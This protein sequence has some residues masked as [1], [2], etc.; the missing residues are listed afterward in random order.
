MA[1]ANNTV[2]SSNVAECSICLSPLSQPGMDVF[3]TSCQHQFHFQCL[4]KNVQAQNA[5]CPLCRAHLA[6]LAQLINGSPIASAAVPSEKAPLELTPSIPTQ[7]TSRSSGLWSTLQ[8]SIS[9]VFS[10]RKTHQV[11]L[12]LPRLRVSGF[13]PDW[14]VQSICTTAHISYPF[15][16][17]LAFQLWSFRG[18]PC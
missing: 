4:A 3:T 18:R 8:R 15:K 5:E 1:T 14:L 7:P 11:D 10:G 13:P 16:S 9:R 2:A 6:S 17:C 12:T